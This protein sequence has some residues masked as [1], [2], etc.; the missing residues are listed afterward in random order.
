MPRFY[1]R[2]VEIRFEDSAIEQIDEVAAKSN[3][4]RAEFIRKA[5]VNAL[6]VSSQSQAPT[7]ATKP[8]LT[9]SA[10]HALVQHVYRSMG[11]SVAR[12]QAETC[13]AIVLKQMLTS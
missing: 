2:K 11:G 8:A 10:Y 7:V 13:V 4:S 9:V 12:I 3:L 6:N 1:N 5:T